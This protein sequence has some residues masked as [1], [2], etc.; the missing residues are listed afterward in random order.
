MLPGLASMS[1][2]PLRVTPDEPHGLP[3]I[4]P[5]RTDAELLRV[6]RSEPSAF[7][8]VYRRYCVEIHAWFRARAPHDAAELTAE[9]LRRRSQASIASALRITGRRRR[10]STGSAQTCC[11]ATTSENESI[12]TVAGR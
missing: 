4:R 11:G 7:A 5:A 10:G 6:A 3:R 2:A 9:T 1:K 8:E 12:R